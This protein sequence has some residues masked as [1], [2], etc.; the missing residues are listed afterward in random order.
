MP[1][2]DIGLGTE[3]LPQGAA[4]RGHPRSGGVDIPSSRREQPTEEG[5]G[6]VGSVP[7]SLEH[8]LETPLP[9]SHH[10]PHHFTDGSSLCPLQAK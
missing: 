9:A 8:P 2:L 6:K 5:Q 1:A 10:H 7:P 3:T 4:G